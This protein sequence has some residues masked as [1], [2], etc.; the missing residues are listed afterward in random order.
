MLSC[1]DEQLDTQDNQ[2]R[3][4]LDRMV[5]GLIIAPA[6][7]D[8]N[9]KRILDGINVPV[10]LI[11]RICEGVETDAVIL[12]NRRAVSMQ[13]PI[14]SKLGH[15]RIGYVSGSL[16]T[17]TGRDRLAG[18]RAALEAA[19]VAF[20]ENLVRLGQ[21]PRGGCLQGRDAASHVA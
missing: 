9:L 11:D 12:D 17:S 14:C 6:G 20:D 13:S 5:D 4:L 21:F 3:L 10:V 1:N 19:G 16:D 18:Y 2:I 15:R 7:D 8:T